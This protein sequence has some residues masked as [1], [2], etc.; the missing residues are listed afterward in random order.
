MSAIRAE[1]IVHPTPRPAKRPAVA[2]IIPCYNEEIAV[3]ATVQGFRAALPEAAV[4]V[5][6]NN[7]RDGTRAA[8]AAAG[9]VVRGESRQGKGNVVRR[10]FAD[11]EADVYVLVDGDA[12][13]DPRAAPAMID[14]LVG[15]GLDMVVGC[16]RDQVQGAYRS[17]HRFGNAVLTRFLAWMFGRAFTDTLS[18]YR[19]F[20]R[21][22]VKTF[23]SLSSGFEVETEINVHALALRMPV[24]EMETQYA[25]RM[26]G[27]TSK[28]STYG[29]G[30]RIMMMMLHLFRQERPAHF[31]AII[32]GLLAAV[33]A[34]LFAP[35]AVTFVHIH[36]VP[37]MP[38]AVLCTGLVIV[39]MLSVTCGLIL[40]TVTHGRRE[41]RR[42]A[43]LACPAPHAESPG[44]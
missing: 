22:F 2:V 18:G 16:R 41:V 27:S 26:E 28:L 17:G 31:F 35:L 15:E 37:R 19:V 8:A 21:R 9:A 44:A 3:G 36:A 10:M 32:A 34:I 25:E 14:K 5:Y 30:V 33:A 40:D 13:Y 7:S 39:A 43:Y 4:Y 1:P 6:D 42:L 38:T 12:T 20:S 24:G 23:P 11:V 29:D